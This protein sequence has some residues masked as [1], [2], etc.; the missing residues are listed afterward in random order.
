MPGRQGPHDVDVNLSE[1]STGH[2][3]LLD[4][5][6][7]VLGDLG[8]LAGD[9]LLA[10]LGDVPLHPLPH[11]SLREQSPRCP[12]SR[13]RQVVYSAGM[14][15]FG[16]PVEI[17]HNKLISLKSGQPGGQLGRSPPRQQVGWSTGP[18]PA[19]HCQHH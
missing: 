13:V 3:D 12:G 14:M 18:K 15:G 17:S 19:G 10:P 11:P 5:R 7:S 2:R 4:L 9:T 1:P 8:H 16:T 6:D